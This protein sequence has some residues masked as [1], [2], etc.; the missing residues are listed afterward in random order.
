MSIHPTAF[1]AILTMAGVTYLTRI[2][3]FL[4]LRGT[5]LSP[6]MKTLMDILPGCVLISVIAPVIASGQTASIV[7]LVGTAIAATRLPLLP[8]MAIGIALTGVTRFLF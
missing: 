1:I 2:S 8:T 4:L 7:G 5:R 6:R 3:G